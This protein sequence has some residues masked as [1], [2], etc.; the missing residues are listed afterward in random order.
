MKQKLTELKG[1]AENSTITVGGFNT[2]LIIMNRI[3]EHKINKETE[4][5]NNIKQLDIK[6][7]YRTFHPITEQVCSFQIYLEH[8]PENP[9]S[10]NKI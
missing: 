7:I 1:E 4:D 6:D 10:G 2:S 8:C 9:L 3:I 5:L